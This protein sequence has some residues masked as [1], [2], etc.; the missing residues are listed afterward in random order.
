MFA[1]IENNQVVEWPIP[2]LTTLFPNT[3]FPSPLTEAHMPDGYVM[4]DV[5]P[6]PMPGAGEKVVPGLP[7]L[8]DGQ[9]VQS[10]NVVSMD[11][12]EIAEREQA[13][14]V[15]VRAERN[16]LLTESD[17][18]QVADAPVDQAAWAQYRQAL[19]DIT[20]QSGF[21]SAVTWPVAP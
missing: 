9:W 13:K 5:I 7:I 20:T 14:A 17:W 16:R 21:P 8:Q 4:V 12:Q 11:A 6:Q 10:W 18:T 3:S 2:S 15:D 1:K 19:R